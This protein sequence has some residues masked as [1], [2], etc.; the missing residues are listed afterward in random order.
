VTH[1]IYDPAG[2]L[3]QNLIRNLDDI[4]RHEVNGVDGPKGDGIII[5]SLI[6]HDTDR[7]IE[8]FSG[9]NLEICTKRLSDFVEKSGKP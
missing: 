4:R 1:L 9:N 8:V 6:P 3:L 5:G 7:L 2:D